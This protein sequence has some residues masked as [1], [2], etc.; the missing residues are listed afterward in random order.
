MAPAPG[1]GGE[2]GPLAQITVQTTTNDH[3]LDRPVAS[4]GVVNLE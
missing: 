3:R 4:R 2:N 1:G